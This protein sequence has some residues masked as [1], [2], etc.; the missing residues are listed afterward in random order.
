MFQHITLTPTT[1]NREL[2]FTVVIPKDSLVFDSNH[3]NTNINN[4][5]IDSANTEIYVSQR[6][7]GCSA[8]PGV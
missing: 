2:N 4:S 5:D 7:P 6:W 1:G 8:F 3:I